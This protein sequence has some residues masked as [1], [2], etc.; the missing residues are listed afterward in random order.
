MKVYP[1]Q[2]DSFYQ[3]IRDQNV[4]ASAKK[5][6]KKKRERDTGSGGKGRK[7]IVERI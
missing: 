5:R 6:R 2:F 3:I 4:G 1:N 7:D